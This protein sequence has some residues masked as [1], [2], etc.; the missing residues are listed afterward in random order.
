MLV[1]PFKFFTLL[2]CE[3]VYRNVNYIF[4][5]FILVIAIFSFN[6]KNFMSLYN[7]FPPNFQLSN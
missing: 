7:F 2:N 4:F 5:V 3:K 1:D 6:F